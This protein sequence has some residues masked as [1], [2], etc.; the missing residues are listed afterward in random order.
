MKLS[1]WILVFCQ[2]VAGKCFLLGAPNVTVSPTSPIASELQQI[3]NIFHNE[4]AQLQHYV[5]NLERKMINVETSLQQ[6]LNKSEE[7][8]SK[9]TAELHSEK[10]KRIQ[11][12]RDSDDLL[13][14]FFNLSSGHNAVVSKTNLLHNE[15]AVLKKDVQNLTSVLSGVNFSSIVLDHADLLRFKQK[16]GKYLTMVP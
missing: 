14:K 6:K 9:L 1:F 16:Q 4:T 12:Q 8:V 10:T 5:A 11:L 3:L 2:F 15:N 13:F 7:Q